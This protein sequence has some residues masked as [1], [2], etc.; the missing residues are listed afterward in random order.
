ML[1][2]KAH[3]T[4]FQYTYLF[5]N[6]VEGSSKRSPNTA[7]FLK[8]EI[9]EYVGWGSRHNEIVYVYPLAYHSLVYT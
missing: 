9:R 2:I 4:S 1:A 7:I 8:Q 5:G 3:T 6:S